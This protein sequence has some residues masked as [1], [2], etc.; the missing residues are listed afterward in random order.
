MVKHFV[1]RITTVLT[2]DMGATDSVVNILQ[3]AFHC[4]R[5]CKVV[6]LTAEAENSVVKSKKLKQQASSDAFTRVK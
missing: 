4:L 2:T 6:T 1:C 5:S 3:H